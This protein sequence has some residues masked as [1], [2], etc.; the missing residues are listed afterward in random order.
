VIVERDRTDAELGRREVPLPSGECAKALDTLAVVL[1]IMIGPER[2]TF[3]PPPNAVEAPPVEPPPTPPRKRE[4]PAPPKPKKSPPA[5][6]AIAP[7]A[8]V[9]VGTGVL[10]GVAWAIQGSAVITTPVRRL[11]AIAR[12][13]Y[14]P[15]QYTPTRPTAEVTRFGGALLGCAR[16]VSE[17]SL[18]GGFDAGRLATESASFT[19]SSNATA[20]VGVLA[21][22]RFGYRFAGPG[23]TS[24][25]PIL[26]A[27]ISAIVRRDRFT[28]RDEAGRELTLLRPAPLAIQA[29]IGVA[30][31]FF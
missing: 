29:S 16:L 9:A 12:A 30:V 26:A 7:V 24:V 20:V 6:W 2:K 31:H 13:E 18:C 15:V 28:Y 3:E 1:A 25:E 17:L 11:H 4:E 8:E 5:H 19:R 10:P 27:Q 23:G 22:A 21:E 14:W